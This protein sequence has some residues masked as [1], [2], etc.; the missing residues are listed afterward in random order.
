LRLFASGFYLIKSTT[1]TEEV[2]HEFLDMQGLS[3]AP[4]ENLLAKYILSFYFVN[5]V[6]W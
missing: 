2:F 1:N 5:T 6:F 4:M 3:H